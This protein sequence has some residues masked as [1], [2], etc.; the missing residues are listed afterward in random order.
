MK[1][2]P[3]GLQLW[4]LHADCSRDFAATVAAVAEMGYSG[5]ELA[6]YGNLDAKGVK[7][8]TMAAG[9]Q[10]AGMHVRP[11]SLLQNLHAIID[12]ALTLGTHEVVCAW[13]PPGRFVSAV[14]CQELGEQLNRIG[15]SLRAF[16]LRFSYHNH[17]DE[18]KSVEGRPVFD[19]ILRASEPRN[20]AAE[21]DVY[22]ANFA[23]VSPAQYLRS[24]GSRCHLVH[25][26]D[27]SEIGR[28]PVKFSEVFA[29]VDAVGAA[30]WLIVEVDHHS[31]TP[32]ESVRQSLE[33]LRQ[34]GR[35]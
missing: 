31:V 4:S 1:K 21:V 33:Q 27:E 5:V 11:E 20:L 6:G 8:A 22:W 10:I 7:A 9:L 15:A 17:G 16:G 35:A 29:A 24:V 25:L 30:E 23:G 26:K 13:W 18:L 2:I 19:W 32:L 3:V 34:W 28:G 14:A 12:D